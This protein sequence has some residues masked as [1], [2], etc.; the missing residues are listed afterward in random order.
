M[1]VAVETTR[2]APGVIEHVSPFADYA[3]SAGAPEVAVDPAALLRCAGLD[4]DSSAPDE[5]TLLWRKLTLLAPLALLTTAARD[6]L[7]PAREARPDLLDALVEETAAAAAANGATVDPAA[8][9]ERLHASR[10]DA[11]LD[12]QGCA[13]RGNAGTRRH[14]RP[15]AR[16]APDGAPVTRRVVAEITR[17][18]HAGG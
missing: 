1:T 16:A 11:V 6:A 13:R 14:R 3:V 2:V 10:R 8:V 17:A 5:A 18:L 12:A 9:R 4:V 7:G 15:G